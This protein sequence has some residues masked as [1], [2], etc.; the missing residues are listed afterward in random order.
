MRK[1]L[2]L[3][4]SIPSINMHFVNTYVLCIDIENSVLTYIKKTL[5]SLKYN[6]I[7]PFDNDQS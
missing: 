5:Q 1:H 7:I 6:E 2:T 4:A 3:F